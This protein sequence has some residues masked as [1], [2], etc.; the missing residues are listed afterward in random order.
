MTRKNSPFSWCYKGTLNVSIY[1]CLNFDKSLIIEGKEKL[2]S[3]RKILCSFAVVFNNVFFFS[4]FPFCS[5]LHYILLSFTTSY[6]LNRS[7]AIV[8]RP[9][10]ESTHAIYMVKISFQLSHLPYIFT[11][12][13]KI[14]KVP[15]HANMAFKW[16]QFT[17]QTYLALI[18][19][20]LRLSV[21]P[22]IRSSLAMF[23]LALAFFL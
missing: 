12:S 1:Q 19:T 6:V 13:R 23:S 7:V 5:S 8:G 16:P 15:F 11:R 22:I 21:C 20:S 17:F 18:P 4:N 9:F 14:E 10:Q 3:K 2:F